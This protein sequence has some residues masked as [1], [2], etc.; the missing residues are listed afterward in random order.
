MTIRRA[1]LIG[2]L[3]LPTLSVQANPLHHDEKR[4]EKE[5]RR[6]EKREKKEDR[7]DE[8]ANVREDRRDEK[9]QRRE[10]RGY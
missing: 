1:L 9:E 7:R 5:D 2:L 8:K 10:D 4:E 3:S 6:A